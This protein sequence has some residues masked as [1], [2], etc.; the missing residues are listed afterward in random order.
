M[1]EQERK[2]TKRVTPRVKTP[3]GTA[4]KSQKSTPQ[5]TPKDLDFWKRK[6]YSTPDGKQVIETDQATV[7]RI[8]ISE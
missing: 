6:A 5:L 2:Y 7:D 3:K 1:S 8:N 4:S